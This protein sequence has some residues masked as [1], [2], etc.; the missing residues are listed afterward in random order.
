MGGNIQEN[1]L[2]SYLRAQSL[3]FSPPQ[4]S[5]DRSSTLSFRLHMFLAQGRIIRSL[6]HPLQAN[7]DRS[8][9]RIASY[10]KDYVSTDGR[11]CR[12]AEFALY[13]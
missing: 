4:L 5:L 1:L 8:I 11:G 6:S 12:C 9:Q 7:F 3:G 2:L 13:S 10:G